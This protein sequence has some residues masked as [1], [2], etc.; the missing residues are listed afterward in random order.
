[1]S[2]AK[3]PLTPYFV[4]ARRAR[5]TQMREALVATGR[6]AVREEA[7]LQQDSL[8]ESQGCGDDARYTKM[9]DNDAALLMRNRQRRV[10]IHRVLQKIGEG[11]YGFSDESGESIPQ[12]RLEA[13]AENLHIVAE[14]SPC[15][16]QDA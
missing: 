10:D 14:E 4:A 5:L 13:I 8:H 1:M 15:E 16:H 7:E 12:D 11:T 3:T 6:A 2:A 9:Q